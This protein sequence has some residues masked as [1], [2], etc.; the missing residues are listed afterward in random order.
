MVV[1]LLLSDLHGPFRPRTSTR[2]RVTFVSY[3]HIKPLFCTQIQSGDTF[4]TTKEEE[5]VSKKKTEVVNTK[6][7]ETR[8]KR[9]VVLEDGKVVE[10]SGPQV[11]TNTTEDSETQEHHQTELKK[12]GED[13]DLYKITEGK[14]A[15]DGGKWVAVANPDG[16]VREVKERRVISREETEE[17]KETED[18][19]HLGDITDEDFLA[20]VNSGRK[21]VRSV[22][23]AREAGKTLV[24]TGPR[25]IRDTNKSNKVTDTEETR[26]L[27]SVQADGKIITETQRTTEHEELDDRELPKTS[28]DINSHKESSQRYFKAREQ[29]EVDYYADGV[30][31]GHEMRFKGETTEGERRGDG[32]DDTDWDSLSARARRRTNQRQYQMHRYRLDAAPGT[33]LL[34]RKDALTRR[35]LD[36]D[37]EE[38]THEDEKEPPATSFFN[39]T[40]KSSPKNEPAVV[41]PPHHH[42]THQQVTHSNRQQ[43]SGYFKGISEWS[44]RRQQEE[45]RSPVHYKTK[46]SPVQDYRH[47]SASPTMN[48]SPGSPI[49]P[50][51][52][53]HQIID[54]TPVPPQRQRRQRTSQESRY[55]SGYRTPTKLDKEE[56]EEPPPDYSPPTPPPIQGEKKIQKTRFAETSSSHSRE[57]PVP[58]KQKSG[59][60]IGQSIRKLVGKIRS[61]SAERKAKQRAKQ[62]SPSPSYQPGH[63]IDRDITGTPHSMDKPV[64]RYYLG[65]DPFAGSIYGRENKYDGVKPARTS[66]RQGRDSGRIEY[67]E[68]SAINSL[69]R[70]SK[71]TPR[72]Q[73]ATTHERFSQT[74]PRHSTSKHETPTRLERNEHSNSTINV[75]I[76][77]KHQQG[78]PSPPKPQRTF[79]TNLARSKSFQTA[80][81]YK[82]NPHLS[83]INDMQPGLSGLTSPGL[84]SSLSRSQRDLLSHQDTSLGSRYYETTTSTGNGFGDDFSKKYTTREYYMTPTTHEDTD[85]A[86]SNFKTTSILKSTSKYGG[87][88]YEP[89]TRLRD[90]QYA[91]T[92][93][94]SAGAAGN[95]VIRRGSVSSDFS[96]TYHT[97]TKNDDPHR[98]SITNTTQNISR[99]T[100]PSKDGR[101]LQTIESTE[102]HSVTRSHYKGEPTTRTYYDGESGQRYGSVSPVVIEVKHY[103]NRR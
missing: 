45:R 37:A 57:T 40:I 48:R 73:T 26:E 92:S 62:R 89:P 103:N 51:S 7:I 79:K 41:N 74:L 50:R 6:Q 102:T 86:A 78:Q 80:G 61:A 81:M 24:S 82:S 75:S 96:E 85:A 18:V 95:T 32:L 34:E 68:R 76:I 15:V 72:L 33:S 47:F 67:E 10:D 43:Q 59:N 91:T 12:L 93:A 64:Q 13:D 71:S 35:P 17:V 25:L 3:V 29:E 58:T 44:E 8:V 46:S 53:S 94:P 38:E 60:I 63:Q 1:I 69:G 87:D 19:Q 22:L 77:N 90:T 49:S 100:L 23:R 20:A 14:D 30:K 31:I 28:E 55:D 5:W 84:I 54:S 70:F 42:Q 65:E 83:R 2:R 52:P 98:P 101:A 97:T 39:V 56:P 27:S 21:D 66:R 11:T 9:Q 99:K 16:V 4:A 36:F 88:I